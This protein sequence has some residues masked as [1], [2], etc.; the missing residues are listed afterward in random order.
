MKN[1]AIKITLE[2]NASPVTADA[3]IGLYNVTST[4][5]AN[6]NTGQ[7]DVTVSDGSDF[8]ADNVVTIT[9]DNASEQNVIDS[10][11]GNVLTM[12]QN[13][14]NNY[15]TADN[16]EVN[17]NSEFRWIP[18]TISGVSNWK[19]GI[20][21]DK[22]MAKFSRIIDLLRGG[23]IARPG[24][25]GVTVKNTSKF[26]NT[27]QGKSIYF[28]GKR[29]EYWLFT[30]ST[31]ARKWSGIC[32]D[33]RW[34][35]K[36]YSIPFQGYHAKR[37]ANV[38]KVINATDD[39][40]ATGD[41]L[42]KAKPVTIG[43]I[44]PLFD[45]DDNVIYNGYAKF[46]RTANK[47]EVFRSNAHNALNNNVIMKSYPATIQTF[48]V[49][50]EPT[51][52]DLTYDIKVGL[53]TNWYSGLAQVTSGA[54][55]LTDFFDD[56][57]IHV[58]E[59]VGDDSFRRITAATVNIDVDSTLIKATIADYF[60]DDLAGNATATATDNSWVQLEKIQ[61][62]YEVDTQPCNNYLNTSGVT[63][64]NNFE[65]FA[66]D[67][68][69]KINTTTP[70]E[71]DP[72]KTNVQDTPLQFYRLPSYGYDDT[73][74][75]DNNKLDIDV[76]FFDDNPDQ[77]NSFLILPIKEPELITDAAEITEFGY[78]GWTYL[79][80]GIF[81][82]GAPTGSLNPDF[83]ANLN[84]LKHNTVSQMYSEGDGGGGATTNI[85]NAFKF[86]LPDYPKRWGFDQM[87]F[88]IRGRFSS[89][90]ALH[91]TFR[92]E[93]RWRRFIGPNSSPATVQ[94]DVDALASASELL[95]ANANAGQ[96]DVA[97]VDGSVFSANYFV[98]IRDNS[99][100]SEQGQVDSVAVNTVTLKA[101][102]VNSY[103]TGLNGRLLSDLGQVNEDILDQYYTSSY[104][105]NNLYFFST[106]PEN[107]PRG[108]LTFPINDITSE[109][110]YN[111][112]QKSGFFVRNIATLQ[113]EHIQNWNVYQVTMIFRKS[114][115]IKDALYSPFRGRIFNDTW[116]SRKTASAMIDNPLN[117]LEHF[118]RLQ[119]YSDSSPIPTNGWGKGYA[120]GAKIK[121]GITVDGSF[122][123]NEDPNFVS[124]NDYQIFNQEQKYNLCYTDKLKT[125]V[126]RNFHMASWVDK[127]GFECVKRIL[128]ATIAP[129]DI[130]TF[131]DIID[132]D[133]VKL[134]ERPSSEIFPEPFVRYRKNFASGEFEST[135]RVTNVSANSFVSGYVEGVS[136]DTTAET[137]WD[138]CNN[139]W[140]KAGF[141]NKPPQDL[142]DLVWINSEDADTRA[143]ENLT[144]WVDWM[145]NPTIKLNVHYNLAGDW[146]EAHRFLLNLPNQTNGANVECILTKNTIDPNDTYKVDLEAIILREAVV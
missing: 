102:L 15:T 126:C 6:A 55:T 146:E 104:D 7:K 43:Q 128:N 78:G 98:S 56:Y 132:R 46:Q 107:A 82:I 117:A 24:S 125:S 69:K 11:A 75:G 105:T 113:D 72:L 32:S 19:E 1:F 14:V 145:Y 124:L 83:I 123:N 33:P 37:I 106:N 90:D 96:K 131:S 61:S 80:D 86:K 95:T 29:A 36:I 129:T 49:V 68:D 108:Y 67:N 93:F 52:P 45:S 31:P 44:R 59:G 133:K 127:N 92:Q 2:D 85:M 27:I 97:V 70:A 54:L 13:L 65:L 135:I 101:N 5:A 12:K 17:G 4:M 142:T 39:P 122:D 134:T 18:N 88:G 87:Y 143:L 84:D 89:F 30:D 35:S 94:L 130:I 40:N 71:D 137:L 38:T 21:S 136:D 115:S 103:T 42:D 81:K 119:D 47:I 141:I 66:F 144:N 110:L 3:A 120:L 34:D 138:K 58:V 74:N 91:A 8:L 57:Y 63:I 53:T 109:K 64:T 10:I 62:D 77:M 76:K 51:D 22:G 25:G 111:S 50:S 116:E 139:L 118:D 121:T 23:N 60:E 26:W 41:I 16:G 99:G 20:I 100:A 114:I 112:I 9:D 73:G 79:A 48:P 140:K 28:N